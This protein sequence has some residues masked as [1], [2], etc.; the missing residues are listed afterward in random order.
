MDC[1]FTSTSI[2]EGVFGLDCSCTC[3]LVDG[4]KSVVIK[5]IFMSNKFPLSPSDKTKHP[6]QERQGDVSGVSLGMGARTSLY[7][8]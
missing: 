1:S 3:V 2:G 6:Y 5:P 8:L 7:G 4:T